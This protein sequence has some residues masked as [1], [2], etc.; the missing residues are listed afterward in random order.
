MRTHLRK[1]E[2]IIEAEHAEGR[3]ALQEPVQHLERGL[4]VRERAMD[5]FGA[6]TEVTGERREAEV[7]HLVAH[8]PAGE[9][10]GVDAAVREARIAVSAERGVEEGDVE[11][12]V[13]S[14]DDGAR[15][16]GPDELE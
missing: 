2:E 8:E 6:S 9:R 1:H 3:G 11:A 16:S 14:A 15:V 10:D 7:R 4:R 13:V 12:D 5:R